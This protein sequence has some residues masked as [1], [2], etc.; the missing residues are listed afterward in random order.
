MDSEWQIYALLSVFGEKI[1]VFGI[2]G[3]H[4]IPLENSISGKV[5]GTEAIRV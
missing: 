2:F 3:Q 1:L 4:F 5:T